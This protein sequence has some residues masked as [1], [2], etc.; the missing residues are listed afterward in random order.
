MRLDMGHPYLE[1][2]AMIAI[3]LSYDFPTAAYLMGFSIVLLILW[4]R[5]HNY[6]QAVFEN[7]FEREI[8]NRLM[9]PRS[10]VNFWGKTIALCLVWVFA[11]AALMQPKGNE[12]YPPG[13]EP[14]KMQIRQKSHEVLFLIDASA[15]MN[16][17][18]GPNGQ[19]R[20]E[21]AK[22]I[23]DQIA[24]LLRG[25]TVSLYAFTS[26]LSKLM[27]ATNDTLF[28]R[29]LL[30][31][32]QINEGDVPGTDFYEAFSKLRKDYLL[33]PPTELKTILLFSDGGDTLYQAAEGAEK[34]RRLQKIVGQLTP[35]GEIS[36]RT[37]PVEIGSKTGGV[38]PNIQ[39]EGREVYSS[40]EHPLMQ[41]IAEAARGKVFA[42]NTL[43]A[44]DIASSL[45]K[46]INEEQANVKTL[47]GEQKGNGK[48][49]MIYD[50]YFQYPLAGALLLLGLI[51]FLPDTVVLKK[52][53]SLFFQRIT[54]F[55]FC[56]CIFGASSPLAA[57][58]ISSKQSEAL[59]KAASY[60]QAKDFSK[61]EAIYADLLNGSLSL[62]QIG[63]VR[64]NMGTALLAE[65]KKKE[66]IETFQTLPFG[67]IIDPLLTYRLHVN[68]AIALL[69][70][71]TEALSASSLSDEN[72]RHAISLFL[73]GFESLQSAEKASCEY[74]G[75]LGKEECSLAQELLDMK[76]F[77]KLKLSETLIQERAFQVKEAAPLSALPFLMLSLSELLENV[78]FIE[79]NPL[80]EDLKEQYLHRCVE[81][82]ETWV[83]LWKSIDEKGDEKFRNAYQCYLLVLH[84]LEKNHLKM[85]REAIADC[86]QGLNKIKTAHKEEH[87]WISGYRILLHL[88]TDALMQKPLQLSALLGIAILQQQL[89]QSFPV[90]SSAMGE[91]QENYHSSLGAYFQ[92]KSDVSRIFLGE[93]AQALKRLIDVSSPQKQESPQQS[94][95]KAIEAQAYAQHLYQ[96]Y[97]SIKKDPTVAKIVLQAQQ[98]VVEEAATFLDSAFAAQKNAFQ[99]EL[100][101]GGKDYRCQYHPWNEVIPL[102]I[103]GTH[104][105]QRAALGVVNLS[106]LES[107]TVSNDQDIA[108]TAWKAGL[109][110]LKEP[111]QAGGCKPGGASQESNLENQ[112]MQ[113]VLTALQEMSQ[114]DR[115]PS[116][117][118]EIHKEVFRPW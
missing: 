92:E 11:V 82:A 95:N 70:E 58:V 85:I 63:I 26:E 54:V 69:G 32:I 117:A 107:I 17:S 27:P 104:A 65:G 13:Q 83:P 96:Y 39:F 80:P 72:Y 115:I 111:L 98:R 15:S 97:L 102:F 53:L 45:A 91:V 86:Q 90:S 29:L 105:A 59:Q 20:F 116:K 81:E 12:R 66:A 36:L 25:E 112:P 103:E 64:Y 9:V 93:A 67:Q 110:K 41:G 19:T 4:I 62:R 14:Q 52:N 24:S 28:L 23:A 84:F 8:L 114:E 21:Y 75:L 88:Y 42:A 35:L 100:V 109:A 94:L 113:D 118:N 101:P 38:V 46:M 106:Q 73:S 71:A 50:L 6:R 60:Y 68:L 43:S 5:L 79:N 3:D 2:D 108:L 57:G 74:Q 78:D 7:G 61:A 33:K 16:V 89:L 34:Q 99:K 47:S 22:E 76:A 10:L 51:L 49:R 77:I 44:I 56:L 48:E 1:A 87:F 37:F 40:I 18:D 55:L 31:D 30:R